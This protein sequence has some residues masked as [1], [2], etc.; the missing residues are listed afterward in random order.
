MTKV[1]FY[2]IN[3][4]S[5]PLG[6]VCELVQKAYCSSHQVLC[7]VPSQQVANSLDSLLWT[8]NPASFIPHGVGSK[9]I[10]VA[11]STDPFPG[12][13]YQLLINLCHEIPEWFSR[14]E[15]IIEIVNS[16]KSYQDS[17]RENFQFYKDR[18]YP[19]GFYDLT[20]RATHN[21]S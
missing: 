16:D 20:K 1:S 10:P 14:F 3:N 7:Q 21:K 15:R 17:K 4:D 12:D 13:H 8:H 11:I 5:I 2:K 19:L 9:N 6:L 18:G